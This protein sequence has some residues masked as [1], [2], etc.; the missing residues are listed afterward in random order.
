MS[1]S[2]R[3][4][5]TGGV[6]VLDLGG[7]WRGYTVEPDALRETLAGL[8][9]QGERRFVLNMTDLTDMDSG[10]LGRLVGSVTAVHRADAELALLKPRRAVRQLLDIVRFDLV[11]D[12]FE[13]EE[14][15]LQSFRD[16]TGS[17]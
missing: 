9:E 16:E 3:K 4:R 14:A 5:E 7:R 17:E 15:A 1:L 10:A 8:L 11:F 12:I 13:D 6:T 2:I